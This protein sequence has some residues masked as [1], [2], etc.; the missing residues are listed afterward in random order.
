VTGIK[1]WSIGGMILTGKLPKYLE[2]NMS[3]GHL[4]H[5]ESNVD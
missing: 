3:L 4:V 1:M 2:K 5:N